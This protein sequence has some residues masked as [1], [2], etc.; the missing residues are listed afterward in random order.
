[1]GIEKSASWVPFIGAWKLVSHEVAPPSGAAT[2]PYGDHPLGLIIYSWDGRMSAQLMDPDPPAFEDADPAKAETAEAQ[3]TWRSYVGYWGSFQVNEEAA[4]V[5]H[6]VDGCWF[7]NGIG[8]DLVR[9]YTF[10][11]DRLILEAETPF[12]L[13]TLTWQRIQ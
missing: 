6:H 1:M 10:S 7:R 5:T 2:R 9:R 13:A 8:Q 11:G 4:T 12:G 3:R